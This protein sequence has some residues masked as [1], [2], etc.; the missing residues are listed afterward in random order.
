[1]RGVAVHSI[2]VRALLILAALLGRT[3]A[4]LGNGDPALFR[5]RADASGKLHFSSSITN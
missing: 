4:R 2:S 3:L 5:D 1:M